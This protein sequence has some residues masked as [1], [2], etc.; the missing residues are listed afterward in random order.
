MLKIAI[1][2]DNSDFLSEAKE[3][4]N[5]WENKPQ[6]LSVACFTSGGAL[7]HA[8]STTPFDI[9]LL[10]VVMPGRSGIETARE[11][12]VFDK[13]TKI[14]FLTS[15]TEFA[16]DS[17][18]VKASNYLLKPLNPDALYRCFDELLTELQT[19]GP[20]SILIRTVSATH[21]VNLHQIEY[22]EAQDK[23]TNFALLGG[24]G[25]VSTKALNS[26]ED[27]LLLSDGFFKCHRSYI[28]NI[29]RID[30]FTQKEIKTQ[31]GRSIP[32]SRTYQ[33]NFE[34]AYFSV[35]FGTAGEKK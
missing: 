24:K 26:Y 8:H 27:K 13:T 16:L 19:G 6:D 2:D 34:S 14:V 11:I 17:Y 35:L 25:L 4:L 10:D 1:C 33:K 31:S 20:A 3:K 23:H 7:I 9:I 12:R 21:R 28:V 32:V 29:H 22:I 5:H 30:S 18:S 15:S